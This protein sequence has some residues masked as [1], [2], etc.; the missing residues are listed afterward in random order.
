MSNIRPDEIIGDFISMNKIIE[1]DI[2]KHESDIYIQT[3]STNPLIKQKTI[4]NAL[5]YFIKV[6]NNKLNSH[7]SIFSVTKILSRLYDK[8]KK[9]I[10]HNP[11]KLIRTQDLDPI[12]EENSCIYIFTKESFFEN[13]NK[14]IGKNP[15]I[16]EIDSTEAIDIDTEFDFKLAETISKLSLNEQI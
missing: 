12:Y 16:F 14:R 3:H 6:K 7:D 1:Y 8:S 2:S 4:D 13:S 15:E 5:K 9:P 10:N 11:D